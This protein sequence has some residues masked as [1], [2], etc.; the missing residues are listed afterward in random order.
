MAT[1]PEAKFPGLT[2]EGAMAESMFGTVENTINTWIERERDYEKA[3]RGEEIA[4]GRQD[5]EK[6]PTLE[7]VAVSVALRTAD[8]CVQ[9]IAVSNAKTQTGYAT[10]KE[11][12]EA[13]PET[14]KKWTEVYEVARTLAQI[15]L[16]RNLTEH[17]SLGPTVNQLSRG[18]SKI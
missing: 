3:R 18:F 4:G 9:E 6:E 11:A 2:N 17:I 8:A 10:F 7:E 5:I 16:I 15:A 1:P 12:F 14:G 13:N